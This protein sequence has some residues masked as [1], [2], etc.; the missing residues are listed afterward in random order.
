MKSRVLADANLCSELADGEGFPVLPA[1]DSTLPGNHFCRGM[2]VLWKMVLTVAEE[3]LQEL[4]WERGSCLK[5]DTPFRSAIG[6]N[7][8]FSRAELFD[9]G[10]AFTALRGKRVRIFAIEHDV[11]RRQYTGFPESK[12][13]N[14]YHKM[15]QYR[16]KNGKPSRKTKR[17]LLRR[18]ADAFRRKKQV[19]GEFSLASCRL[20]YRFSANSNANCSKPSHKQETA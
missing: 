4:Q 3:Q 11:P 6:A 18:R 17:N 20:R 16:A 5:R 2:C 19:P 7:G 15:G 12:P 10:H 8:S 9:K 13:E 14:F 1:Q